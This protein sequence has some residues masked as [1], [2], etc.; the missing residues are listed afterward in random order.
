M[1][2]RSAYALRKEGEKTCALDV[3]VKIE[4]VVSADPFAVMAVKAGT[5]PDED[6]AG[7]G[8]DDKLVFSV[9]AVEPDI[10]E[11][12][13]VDPVHLDLG[14]GNFFFILPDLLE[15][16]LKGFLPGQGLL[17]SEG[18]GASAHQDHDGNE[19]RNQFLHVLYLLN[20]SNLAGLLYRTR[21]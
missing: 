17:F 5:E 18:G 12:V 14:H 16:H 11:L 6:A 13:A 3:L 21:I 20:P 2:N 8:V 9:S 1:K 4:D 10:P 15:S 7:K 19:A